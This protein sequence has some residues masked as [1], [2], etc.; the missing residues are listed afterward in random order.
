MH[1]FGTYYVCV[2]SVLLVDARK[3]H[4]GVTDE[5]VA[6]R[7][8]LYL[9]NYHSCLSRFPLLLRRRDKGL[10]RAGKERNLHARSNVGSLS[11]RG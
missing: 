3:L 5:L 4:Y 7:D 2:H 8:I 11:T 6:S 1:R 10:E 9:W